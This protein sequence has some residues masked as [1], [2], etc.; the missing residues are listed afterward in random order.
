MFFWNGVKGF[1]I[2]N[3]YLCIQTWNVM[4]Y[5]LVKTFFNSWG[6][7]GINFFLKFMEQ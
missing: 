6:F 5:A 1:L 3:A 2:T 4:V 7:E